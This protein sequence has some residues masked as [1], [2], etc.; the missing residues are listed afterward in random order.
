MHRMASKARYMV[1]ALTL[2][3]G[4]AALATAHPLDGLSPAEMGAVVEILKAEGK[5]GEEARFPLIEL[6]E[7]DKAIARDWALGKPEPRVATVGVKQGN[8]AFKGEV[9]LAAR[10]VL[11]WVPA[12]GES[13]ILLEEFLGAMDLALADSEVVAGLE[14]R[15]LTPKDAFCLPLTAGAFGLPEEQDRRLMKVPCYVRPQGSNFYAKP[16]EGLFPVVDLKAKKVVD[17]VDTGVVP[18]PTDNWGYTQDEVQQRLG[19]LRPLRSPPHWRNRAEPTSR[20]TAVSSPGTC[21]GSAGASTSDRVW[22]CR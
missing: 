7:P 15:G 3:V 13:M 20:S 6:K 2:S 8:G 16:I 19:A 5:I 14:K 9:D 12:T 11:S 1:S 17:V 21:G 4:W 22:F 18:V 10:K